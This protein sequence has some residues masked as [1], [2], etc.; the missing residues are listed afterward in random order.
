MSLPFLGML[1]IDSA[2]ASEFLSP[3]RFASAGP[4]QVLVWQR[5][6][7]W[8]HLFTLDRKVM[9]FDQFVRVADSF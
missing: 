4:M 8:Y 7:V 1:R 2:D 3:T 5:D 9:A 6:G